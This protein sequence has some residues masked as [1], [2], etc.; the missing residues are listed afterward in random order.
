[1]QI[2]SAKVHDILYI[3]LYFMKYFIM[4][5]PARTMVHSYNP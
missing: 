1:M 3:K 5:I 2:M 4:V